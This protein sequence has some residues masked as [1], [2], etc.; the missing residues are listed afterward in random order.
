MHT[1]THT[2]TYIYIYIY[3]YSVAA[4]VVESRLSDGDNLRTWKVHT[5]DRLYLPPSDKKKNLAGL[6]IVA[7]VFI[8]MFI[9]ASLC[10]YISGVIRGQTC[11]TC[12]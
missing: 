1:H 10:I 2:H 9:K 5:N 6:C 3:I 8:H 4:T 7:A 12:V 11:V